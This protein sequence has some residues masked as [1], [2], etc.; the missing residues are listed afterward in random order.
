MLGRNGKLDLKQTSISL[1]PELAN[2]YVNLFRAESRKRWSR[3]RLPEEMNHA[4]ARGIH[5]V[6]KG[7]A[8]TKRES[9]PRMAIRFLE[10]MERQQCFS[11]LW[12]E[13]SEIINEI[14][15][16]LSI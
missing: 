6:W 1:K 11:A 4:W 3:I 13:K 14:E 2:T 12:N 16:V 15:T 9:P 7:F 10:K 8:A 5:G